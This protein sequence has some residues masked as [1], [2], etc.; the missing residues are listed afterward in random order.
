LTAQVI[1]PKPLQ[2]IADRWEFQDSNW[3]PDF[4]TSAE[5]IRWF[6]SKSGGYSLD[7][8]IAVNANI[9]EKLLAVTGPIDVP[10]LGKIITAE[11]FV[12]ETQKAVE[13]EYDKEE[14]KPKKILS[15]L[16]PRLL[17]R[18]KQFN[19]ED[20]VKLV[21]IISESI[22][23]K[24][25]Q[26][27]LTDAQEDAKAQSYGWSGRLKETKGDSLAIIGSNIAGQKTDTVIKERVTQEIKVTDEGRITDRVTL[28]RTHTGTK[29]TVFSGVRNVE[30]FRF[31]V[32]SGSTLIEAS[33]FDVIPS[34]LFKATREDAEPDPDLAISERLA[35]ETAFNVSVWDEGDRTVIGGW[36]MLD[37]GQEETLVVSYRLPF[38]AFDLRERISEHVSTGDDGRSAY[39]LLLTSQSGVADREIAI[40]L[41]VPKSWNTHWIRS[42]SS[43]E[44]VWNRDRVV[45][46]LFETK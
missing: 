13:L 39:E 7:G 11:N 17:D 44:G 31:Y 4:P 22:E 10:E 32:P 27:A 34:T 42:A 40:S 9:V 16:A 23:N 14:N 36:T 2:L 25:I 19:S 28:K 26:I 46:A 20:M 12:S 35:N 1:P 3:S 41:D 43:V 29:G 15:L 5:K 24:D 8:V 30:Y 18:I 33:G 45:S 38:T 6:W 21:S 37:P